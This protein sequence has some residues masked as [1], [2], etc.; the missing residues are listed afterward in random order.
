MSKLM[1]LF[2]RTWSVEEEFP[3]LF[4]CYS[5]VVS[6]NPHIADEDIESNLK[7]ELFL[8]KHLLYDSDYERSLEQTFRVMKEEKVKTQDIMFQMR[9]IEKK[10]QKKIC[11]FATKKSIVIKNLFPELLTLEEVSNELSTTSQS[12][13]KKYNEDI[14]KLVEINRR[15]QAKLERK[16][17]LTLYCELLK[18]RMIQNFYLN[19]QKSQG[20]QFLNDVHKALVKINRNAYLLNPDILHNKIETI[21]ENF[22][23]HWNESVANFEGKVFIN[24]V[25]FI[26]DT[27][28]VYI[29]N[30]T[31]SLVADMF[32][33]M[34]RFLVVKNIR[35]CLFNDE[36]NYQPTTQ[37]FLL[38]DFF[39]LEILL[40]LMTSGNICKFLTDLFSDFRELFTNIDRYL[41][42]LYNLKV[43]KNRPF[44]DDLINGFMLQ[45]VYLTEHISSLIIKI[46]ECGN[47][48][49]LGEIGAAAFIGFLLAYENLL[50]T[51]K[52]FSCHFPLIPNNHIFNIVN[53]YIKDYKDKSIRTC[54]YEVF[55]ENWDSIS[56]NPEIFQEKIKKH[57]NT[58]AEEKLQI[59]RYLT[60][61]IVKF[62]KE[63]KSSVLSASLKNLDKNNQAA[64]P[65]SRLVV[66]H[67]NSTPMHRFPSNGQ[68]IVRSA[69][70]FTTILS[71][72]S[73]FFALFKD[74]REIIVEDCSFVLNIWIFGCFLKFIAPTWMI[75][76]LDFS[77]EEPPKE[78][79]LS[80]IESKHDFFV[81]KIRYKEIRRL[82]YDFNLQFFTNK[83]QFQL[84]FKFFVNKLLKESNPLYYTTKDLLLCLKSMRHIF[85]CYE[86]L[87]DEQNYFYNKNLMSN[88]ERFMIE[89]F[90]FE[91]FKNKPFFEKIFQ[92]KWSQ[93]NDIIPLS[94]N[95]YLNHFLDLFLESQSEFLKISDELNIERHEVMEYMFIISEMLLTILLEFYSRAYDCTS[96]G[97]IQM[98]LDLT[99]VFKSIESFITESNLRR[100][101][102]KYMSYVENFFINSHKE[103]YQYIMEHFYEFSFCA[104][105]IFVLI[106]KKQDQTMKSNREI[107]V[108][109]DQEKLLSYIS[110]K[111][112]KK[113][114]EEIR[115]EDYLEKN[116]LLEALEVKEEIQT[117]EDKLKAFFNFLKID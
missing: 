104:S 48:K 52:K 20:K 93:V 46:L 88:I 80:Y 57:I 114:T 94:K 8:K 10:L 61:D 100:L 67:Q 25:E 81:F 105:K 5:E 42:H 21:K 9:G 85:N 92:F 116:I 3:T 34:V 95:T 91:K 111:V 73:K 83:D 102:D 11:L 68:F 41:L 35:S 29:F 108:S 65:E 13:R 62:Q 47:L 54:F 115:E 101:Q 59:S 97:R 36:F 24:I 30:S 4:K 1:S 96:I 53:G 31:T 103:V 110:Q 58:G 27:K 18:K 2:K 28:K 33:F 112:Y 14:L 109:S 38:K 40:P 76:L 86:Y 45:K 78:P 23:L 89:Y 63:L 12:M 19:T 17:A 49:E 82:F 56:F 37:L 44:Y 6:N 106:N 39:K 43:R 64:S 26:K 15:I 74:Y 117:N 69:M 32:K 99:E 50:R 98:K 72:Y 16:K 84:Y 79:A 66:S 113:L 71:D 107:L 75:K 60:N 51:M 22:F 7:D 87:D 77:Y 90:F 55:D 70:T